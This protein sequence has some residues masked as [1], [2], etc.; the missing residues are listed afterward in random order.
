[1]DVASDSFCPTLHIEHID[2]HLHITRDRAGFDQFIARCT[3]S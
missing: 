2:G 1:M 3:A